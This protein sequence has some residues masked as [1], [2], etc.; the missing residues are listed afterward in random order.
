DSQRFAHRK[1]NHLSNNHRTHKLRKYTSTKVRFYV[2]SQYDMFLKRA[3][4]TLTR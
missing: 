1:D 3:C 2:K 4:K